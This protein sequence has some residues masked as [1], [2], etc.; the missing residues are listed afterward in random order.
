MQI[1]IAITGNLANL[2]QPYKSLP[3]RVAKDAYT[4]FKN[5]TPRGDPRRWKTKYPPKNY[6][7]GNAQRQTVMT[8]Q[9]AF[10][11]D[12]PYAERLDQGWSSQ[13]PKGMIEPLRQALPGIVSKNINEIKRSQGG[14]Q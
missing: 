4:F 5:H 12:Y 3:Q 10:T 9:T 11:A 6:Q 1:K 2:L 8:S 14:H 13:A 7:P